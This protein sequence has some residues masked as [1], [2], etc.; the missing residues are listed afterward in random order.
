MEQPPLREIL[1]QDVHVDC[2]P[3]ISVTKL[4]T[5]LDSLIAQNAQLLAQQRQLRAQLGELP[6]RV[7]TLLASNRVGGGLRG[8]ATDS[9]EIGATERTT[10]LTNAPKARPPPTVAVVLPQSPPT[11]AFEDHRWQ[12]G[13]IHRL[14]EA[15]RLASVNVDEAW[16]LWWCGSRAKNTRPLCDCASKDCSNLTTRQTFNLWARL[17]K[18]MQ[19][20]A[21]AHGG[22]RLTGPSTAQ[23]ATRAFAVAVGLLDCLVRG[24]H[25]RRRVTMLRVVRVCDLL[26]SQNKLLK[27]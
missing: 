4:L 6:T 7:A 24:H 23:D 27:L 18:S 15:F 11:P 17:V 20:Y 26:R 14:P 19:M 22:V 21:V 12:D 1:L 10:P 8:G 16:Q 9:F 13:Q 25:G 5:T 3:A 2:T